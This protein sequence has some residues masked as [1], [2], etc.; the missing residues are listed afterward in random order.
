MQNPIEMLARLGDSDEDKTGPK[1]SVPYWHLWTDG[2]GISHQAKCALTDFTLKGVGGA[3]SQW[4][5]QA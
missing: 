5:Q 3:D 2:E 1:P 4:N